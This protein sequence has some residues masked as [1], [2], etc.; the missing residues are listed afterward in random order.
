MQPSDFACLTALVP[1]VTAKQK[2]K[3]CFREKHDFL[4]EKK[5]NICYNEGTE[6]RRLSGKDRNAGK[7]PLFMLL[8]ANA[9]IY[10]AAARGFFRGDLL[11]EGGRIAED[12]RAASPA[13]R[14]RAW[15]YRGNESF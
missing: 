13:R 15:C 12:A 14:K 7:V 6:C 10:D 8:I 1:P 9:A 2:S 5:V 11:L 3:C 4:F